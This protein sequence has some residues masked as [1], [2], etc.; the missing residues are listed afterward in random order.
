MVS[1]I[2]ESCSVGSDVTVNVSELVAT[3]VRNFIPRIALGESWGRT[4]KYADLPKL[5]AQNLGTITFEDVLPS[6]K[7]LDVL[8]GLDKRIK[9]VAQTVEQFLDEVIDD[10]LKSRKGAD[11]PGDFVDTLLAYQSDPA[12]AIDLTRE[13]LKT[14]ILDMYVGGSDML[15]TS[16]EWVMTEVFNH[17]SVMKK[18]QNEIR[19]VVGT[20]SK[21]DESDIIR[22][23][24]LHCVIKETLRIRPTLALLVP[25]LSSAS[26]TIE[27]YHIPANTRV[28]VNAW[29]IL[30]DPKIWDRPE[31]FI[32]ERFID[33]PTDFKYNNDFGFIP[34]GGGRRM[35]PAVSFAT[36]S[37][38]AVIANLFYWFDWKL[39]N[40][41]K[42]KKLDTT[43]C[44]GATLH[45]KYPV[46]L[47]PIAHTF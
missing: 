41:A 30:R 42:E 10:H 15:N 9:D 23:D 14:I 35:C 43:E 39:P 29:A 17:P 47:V 37:L 2:K 38:E 25:R 8:T 5:V 28:Y 24:Y 19:E 20:K 3:V 16:S 11:E 7:W 46:V 36:N 1:I 22:M 32:P 45:K 12:S 31:E 33:S 13:S 34:F 44:S 21:L 27:G 18:L 26:V 4:T 6:L 40:D